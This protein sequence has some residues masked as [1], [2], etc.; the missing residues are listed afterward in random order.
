MMYWQVV[1]C[2]RVEHC[3]NDVGNRII[4]GSGT[5]L[6]I[7]PKGDESLKPSLY[8]LRPSPSKSND[9]ETDTSAACLAT[10][11][12]SNKYNL[13]V[14][15]GD[16][17]KQKSKKEALISIKHKTFNLFSFLSVPRSQIMKSISCQ[18]ETPGEIKN[19]EEDDPVSCI[20]LPESNEDGE[21][22]RGISLTVFGL[23]ILFFKS[24]VFNGLMTVRAWV[25]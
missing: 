17:S 12:F 3:V 13:K 10:E 11:Y 16:A 5:R 4:F 23:R 21:H 24:V 15:I 6:M 7:K 9:Q 22:E 2:T 8:V 20:Q 19:V 18:L 14:T 25:S 1:Y